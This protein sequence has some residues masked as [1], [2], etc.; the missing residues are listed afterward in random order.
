MKN[1]ETEINQ[2]SYEVQ[3]VREVLGDSEEIST[4][5]ALSNELRNCLSGV[6]GEGEPILDLPKIYVLKRRVSSLILDLK[7]KNRLP[8]RMSDYHSC[9]TG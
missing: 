1:L 8:Y 5:S 4:A 6:V 7:H 9:S 3:L 2:L